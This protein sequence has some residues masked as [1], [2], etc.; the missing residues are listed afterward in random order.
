MVAPEECLRRSWPYHSELSKDTRGEVLRH[1]NVVKR[2]VSALV[3]K[4]YT[5]ESE[6]LYKLRHGNLKPDLVVTVSDGARGKKSLVLDV[7]VV[8]PNKIQDWHDK[9][10]RHPSESKGRDPGAAT[11]GQSSNSRRDDF[12]AGVWLPASLSRVFRLLNLTSSRG[13]L[14]S[15]VTRVL[16]G[17]LLNRYTF[18]YKTD[19]FGR[20]GVGLCKT[21]QHGGLLV[22]RY[23]APLERVRF[24]FLI[25]F[26]YISF[27]IPARQSMMSA[28]ATPPGYN[29][30]TPIVY[31]AGADVMS[32]V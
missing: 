30:E 10:V 3:D 17:S 7:Q 22:L 32:V 5:V 9:K 6:H 18:N 4:G 27:F 16:R 23:L 15:L 25:P 11:I 24:S 28:H 20:A 13:L 29:W 19:V 2:I 26:L 1:D 12:V 31:Q 14:A 21:Q 8:S